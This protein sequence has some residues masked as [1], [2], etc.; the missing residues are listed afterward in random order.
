MPRPKDFSG[1]LGNN[2]GIESLSDGTRVRDDIEADER[3]LK[4]ISENIGRLIDVLYGNIKG[5][6]DCSL[7]A[8]KR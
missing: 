1:V 6:S 3:H 5:S 8:P 7:V 2:A 4:D